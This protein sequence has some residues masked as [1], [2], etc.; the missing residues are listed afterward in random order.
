MLKYILLSFLLLVG[1]TSPGMKARNLNQYFISSGVTRY[2]LPDIPNWANFSQSAGCHRKSQIRYFD[3]IKLRESFSLSYKQSV[4]FQEMFN[5]Y[6]QDLLA[7][8]SLDSLP[9]K[10]EEKVFFTVSDKVQSNV[11]YSQMPKFKRVHLIWIDPLI[12]SEQ[13][14]KKLKSK[15]SSNE[16]NLGHP[17]FVSLCLS[18]NELSQ[19]LVDQNLTN[20]N[21]RLI[22]YGFFNLYSSDKLK[23]TKMGLELNKLFEEN[24]KLYF[25]SPLKS[26]PSEIEGDF[27]VKYF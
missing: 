12:S 1:C 23:K 18:H 25:Y 22:S 26:L 14:L 2:F 19:L 17:V 21:I 15:L 16:M 13:G 9:L 3:M 4:H 24:Q 7:E 11:F 8:S 27:N 5:I 6:R 20:M 10:E